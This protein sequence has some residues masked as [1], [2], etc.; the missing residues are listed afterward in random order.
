MP[1]VRS[2]IKSPRTMDWEKESVAFLYNNEPG[3]EFFSYPT[4]GLFPYNEPQLSELLDGPSP[5]WIA[6]LDPRGD[7]GKLDSKGDKSYVVSLPATFEEYIAARPYN[8]RKEFRYSLRKNS[9]VEVIENCKDDITLLWTGHVELLKQRCFEEGEIPFSEQALALA[10]ESYFLDA[11]FTLSVRI[12]GKLQGV[13]I[14]YRKDNV[15][16]DSKFL[17][18]ED[19][20]VKGRGLGIF[21]ILKNIEA[22][23]RDGY[24]EYD[25]LTGDWGY[26]SRFGAEARDIKHFLKCSKTFAQAYGIPEDEI[27][28]I[29]E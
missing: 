25:M 29:C 22:A 7:I 18:L 11:V 20:S 12:N 3:P 26:K 5:M 21:V 4:T 6:Y 14:S 28:V 8:H 27:S 23:I 1:T 9:D 17:R 19:P 13:N 15:V 24:A 10:Y 2:W 16:Y